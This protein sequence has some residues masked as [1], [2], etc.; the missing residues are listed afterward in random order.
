MASLP[1]SRP[2]SSPE[3]PRPLHP[4][5]IINRRPIGGDAP[6]SFRPKRLVAGV[7]PLFEVWRLKFTPPGEKCLVA[8]YIGWMTKARWRRWKEYWP[9]VHGVPLE[10]VTVVPVGRFLL[11]VWIKTEA[12]P[13]RPRQSAGGRVADQGGDVRRRGR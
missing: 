13:T 7:V 1:D 5:E 9:E 6:G 4:F 12:V 11:A 2:E 3:S 10:C 8:V